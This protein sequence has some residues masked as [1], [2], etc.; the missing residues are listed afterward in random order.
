MRLW[1]ALHWTLHVPSQVPFRVMASFIRAPLR[2]YLFVVIH[3]CP[4]AGTGKSSISAALSKQVLGRQNSES[5]MWSGPV[6]ALHFA[7]HSDQRRL[8]PVRIIKS[9]AYQL[10]N[11]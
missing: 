9:L 5:G 4:G 8:D 10:A 11:R 2:I 7:K 1:L 6:T 3:F